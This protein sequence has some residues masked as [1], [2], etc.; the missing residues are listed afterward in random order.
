MAAK[1]RHSNKNPAILS[2]EFFIQNHA[3]IV[4]CI[5]M[6]FSLG[7]M[8]EITSP[9]SSLFIV[10]QHQTTFPMQEKAPDSV[11]SPAYYTSGLMDIPTILFH[12]LAA[13]AFHQVIQEYC[14]DKFNRKLNLS[15]MAHSKLSDT[16]VHLAFFLCSLWWA[17]YILFKENHSEVYTLGKRNPKHIYMTYMI[18]F[19]FIAQ[20]SYWL[21]IFPELYFQKV[22]K[23]DVGRRIS[24]ASIYIGFIG[25]AYV[26]N[27]TRIAF[28]LLILQ[29]TVEAV[30]HAFRIFSYAKKEDIA[31]R[32]YH[33]HSVLFVF[34]RLASIILSVL[35]FWY[36][37]SLPLLEKQIVGSSD[38][39]FN[40]PFFRLTALIAT[41]LLQVWQMW[42]FINVH[43]QKMREKSEIEVSITDTKLDDEENISK[44]QEA[45]KKK[46]EKS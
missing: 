8:F 11:P 28:V 10:L 14:L 26:L 4:S 17:G 41:V 27:F 24:Y 3:E 9:L 34:A 42:N 13:I 7:L 33:L 19:F 2:H 6:I 1:R 36:G 31:R 39:T 44:H 12:V 45:E 23:E 32:L 35:T 20:I 22:Q 25:A 29:Y 43:I 38:G 30:F 5:A 18:K 37:L 15:K 21:H 46:K 40:I 16:G